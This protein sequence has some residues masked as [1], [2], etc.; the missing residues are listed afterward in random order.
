MQDCPKNDL[1]REPE[2][3]L[4][5]HAEQMHA[6]TDDGNPLFPKD[7]EDDRKPSP[8]ERS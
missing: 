3:D 5:Y 7:R 4:R 6:F 8:N 1:P 2:W